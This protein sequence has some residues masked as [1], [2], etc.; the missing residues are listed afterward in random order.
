MDFVFKN[1]NLVL[2][3]AISQI[4][5]IRKYSYKSIARPDHGLLYLFT[6][7]I[8]YTFDD[9][10]IELKP[11]DIIY[12]PKGSNYEVDFDLNNGAVENYLINFDV[13]G[14]ADFTDISKPTLFLNDHSKVMLDCFKDTVNAYNEKDKPFLTNSLFYLCLNSLQAAIHYTDSRMER[15]I[16]EKAAGK[17][18]ENFE[19]SVDAISKEMHMSRSAFQ[20]KFIQYFGISPIQYR[21][22]KR[23]KKAKLLLE[24]TDMPIKEISDAL[25][26]YDTTYFYKVFKKTYSITPKEHR[27]RDNPDF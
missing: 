15:L 2:N 21:V 19:M 25:G 13:I 24:T 17:L 6:G 11:G 16:F 10:K 12:L 14:D 23:L 5:K 22:E 26:F 7:N 20:K 1:T 4:W 9:C 18:A 27:T 3:K 8:A